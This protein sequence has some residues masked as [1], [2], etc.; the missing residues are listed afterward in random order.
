[1]QSVP[2]TL[3]GKKSIAAG[4]LADVFGIEMAEAEVPTEAVPAI[5]K[6]PAK[7]ACRRVQ[8]GLEEKFEASSREIDE[9]R[10]GSRRESKKVQNGHIGHKCNPGSA[11][12]KPQVWHAGQASNFMT[13]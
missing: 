2:A 1:M 3:R 5:A 12:P 7:V 13:V 8:E 9:V 6:T 11:Q 10:G 4:D